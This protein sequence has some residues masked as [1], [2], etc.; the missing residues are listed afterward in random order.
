MSNIE[1]TLA[2]FVRESN[3]IEGILR[4]P[5]NAEI[6]AHK[7]FLQAPAVTV[8][9]LVE[10]VS[11]IQPGAVLRDRLG[12]NVRIGSHYPMPGSPRVREELEALLSARLSPWSR[13]CAY[14]ILHPFMDGN[15][16]SGRALWLHDMGGIER[17]CCAR[18][19]LGF[20]HTFYYQTL[21][22]QRE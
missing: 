7:R 18:V 17:G 5:Y 11:V 3:R 10:L 21:R 8:A 15:G 4:T 14:E 22:R 16:R 20:L 6:E 19:P 2:D 1:F 12:L 13:H 9:G